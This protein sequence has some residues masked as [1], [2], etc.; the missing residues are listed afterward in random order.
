M[1]QLYAHLGVILVCLA[2]WLFGLHY[3]KIVLGFFVALWGLGYCVMSL[4]RNP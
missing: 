4:E 2:L 1:K 3:W